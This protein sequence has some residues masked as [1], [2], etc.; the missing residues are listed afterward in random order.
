MKIMRKEAPYGQ[1]DNKESTGI[2]RDLDL[3]THPTIGALCQS[4][5]NV[6]RDFVL[7][8]SLFFTTKP[9]VLFSE[10]FKG[11]TTKPEHP[12]LVSVRRNNNKRTHRK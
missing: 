5:K 9:R 7:P 4:L 10:C 8:A 1:R 2:Q 12:F 6:S 11:N 3:G